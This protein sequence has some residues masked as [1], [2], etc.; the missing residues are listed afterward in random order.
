MPSLKWVE[1][2]KSM[3]IVYK[4]LLTNADFRKVF[5]LEKI[6]WEVGADDVLPTHVMNAF[7]HSGGSVIGA[8][9]GEELLGFAVG[10]P[11]K[12]GDDWW[13]WS[14]MTGVRPD[15]QKR[16]IGFQLKQ[17]Q[18]TWAL[19]HGFERI[20]WT[21]DPMQ[22]GNANFNIHHLGTVVNQYFINLYGEMFDGINKG[23]ASDRMETVW[24]L[25]DRRVVALASNQPVDAYNSSYPTDAF[26]L[27][28]RDDGSFID[29]QPLEFHANWHFV[30]I[31]YDLKALKQSDIE[32]AKNWQLAL[33]RV[34]QAAM[35]N[36]YA[37]VDFVVHE[38]RCWYVLQRQYPGPTITQTIRRL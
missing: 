33:R 20:K 6:I 24:H 31:P 5:D 38:R 22:R 13:L 19:K 23:M 29:R 30:E 25:R 1:S 35:A 17:T 36:N 8:L 2:I 32:T 11:G 18:R 7:T 21:F 12:Q 9:D 15:Y 34:I 26:L 28:T 16:G 3:N 37:I 10:F 27:Y 4:Q 14:H